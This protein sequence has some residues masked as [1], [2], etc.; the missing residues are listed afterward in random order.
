MDPDKL[1]TLY[2]LVIAGELVHQLEEYLMGFPRQLSEAFHLMA[3][4]QDRFV[5]MILALAAV[6]HVA[7]VGLN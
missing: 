7:A 4:T 1:L 2:L 3:F 6:G 5:V